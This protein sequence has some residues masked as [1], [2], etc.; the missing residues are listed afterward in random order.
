MI[1][2]VVFWAFCD[3]KIQKSHSPNFRSVLR[4]KE[5]KE[6]ESKKPTSGNNPQIYIISQFP[7]CPSDP[8]LG[9]FYSV[10]HRAESA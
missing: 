7:D 9:I 8:Y 5:K 10:I 1:P 3:L 2:W 6:S 4:V